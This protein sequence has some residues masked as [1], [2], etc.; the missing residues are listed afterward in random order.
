ML[1]N[2]IRIK[3]NVEI[4]ILREGGKILADILQSLAEKVKPGISSK[5]L[6]DFAERLIRAGGDKP[7]ILNYQ[8]DGASYPFPASLCVSLNEEIVH[9]IPSERIIKEGDV[10]S[11]D[12][13]LE[14]KGL[15][16]DG[17]ITLSVRNVDPKIKRLIAVTK[18][19]LMAGI[20]AARVGNRIGDIGYEIE[21]CARPYGYGVV[22]D[23]GGHGVGYSVHEA[24]CIQNFGRRGTGMLLEPGM[25][26]A[27]EPMFTLGSPKIKVKKDGYTIVSYDH[28]ISAHFE[29]TIAITEAGPKI[30]TL[31]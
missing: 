28:S 25:V 16:T 18:K 27:L 22:R 30:L 8:P 11:L 13:C 2:K 3:T 1:K 19:A 31:K 23:L 21:S 7:A 26:L 14:H 12:F 15:I 10:V 24:P 17:A 29:H 20:A 4:E 9:G 6:N 5:E